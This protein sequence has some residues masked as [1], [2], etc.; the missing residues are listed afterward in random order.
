MREDWDQINWASL[1]SEGRSV[2]DYA[3]ILRLLASPES[4]GFSEGLESFY[5]Q[6]FPEKAF[7]HSLV[8][9]LPY[10]IELLNL[11]DIYSPL[12]ILTILAEI[13]QRAENVD[14]CGSISPD[15][16]V[17]R[18]LAR[19][20]V[21]SGFRTYLP[22]LTSGVDG[23]QEASLL[24]L[25][26]CGE[27]AVPHLEAFIQEHWEDLAYLPLAFLALGRASRNSEDLFLRG[28]AHVSHD[29]K[30]S[31]GLGFVLAKNGDIPQWVLEDLRSLIVGTNLYRRLAK[32]L[33]VHCGALGTLDAYLRPLGWR[34]YRTL[35]WS[36]KGFP[37]YSL[38]EQLPEGDP[39]RENLA[40]LFLQWY[41]QAPPHPA[42][43]RQI[44][45]S[46]MQRE[47][48]RAFLSCE[49]VW[50]LVS[51]RA[52]II[53]DDGPGPWW[54][55]EAA[56]NLLRDPEPTRITILNPDWEQGAKNLCADL[57]RQYWWD[58][59]FVF[60]K[61]NIDALD[62]MVY[63]DPSPGNDKVSEDSLEVATRLYYAV[64]KQV[65]SELSNFSFYSFISRRELTVLC[66][67]FP[68]VYLEPP[69]R[70]L[71]DR[72]SKPLD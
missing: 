62:F 33:R 49:V 28:L 1:S 52:E 34:Q 29:V 23:L 15:Q 27:D 19:E 32:Q 66:R 50:E 45:L 61:G 18:R 35:G 70:K 71:A 58:G 67:D 7:T 3:Q 65:D 55:R 9:L 31:A 22:Y 8:A 30:L 10:L 21:A 38:L 44:L 4:A 12:H 41:L 72:E 47:M 20:H 40:D 59:V 42:R 39:A 16:R 63:L 57:G 53:K 54:E 6:V 60:F 43:F 14:W 48:I 13:A 2:I 24:A 69:L 37:L 26:W 56:E 46:P 64:V 5:G 25:A 51:A 17:L 36:K 11:S 68:W